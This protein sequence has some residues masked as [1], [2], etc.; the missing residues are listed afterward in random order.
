MNSFWLWYWLMDGDVLAI[1]RLSAIVLCVM[2][3]VGA[4]CYMIDYLITNKR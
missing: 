1:I 3:L 4:S 2:G